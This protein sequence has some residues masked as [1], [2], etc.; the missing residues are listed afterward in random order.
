MLFCDN[1]W[2][3]LFICNNRFSSR[4]WNVHLLICISRFICCICSRQ[5]CCI[6][7]AFNNYYFLTLFEFP[8]NCILQRIKARAP[9][10]EHWNQS[11]RNWRWA[12][13]G[14]QEKQKEN[15]RIKAIAPGSQQEHQEEITKIRSKALGGEHQ[16]KSKTTK[17]TPRLDWKHHENTKRARAPRKHQDQSSI[18]RAEG[19]QTLRSKQEHQD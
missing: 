15:I 11:K 1:I 16:E 9:R 17:K 8:T 18:R 5:H 3:H 4:A 12:P 7:N 19:D 14:K 13:K 2:L 10:G 6:K